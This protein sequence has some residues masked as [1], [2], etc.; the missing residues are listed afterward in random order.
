M[1]A[2]LHQISNCNFTD[3][4]SCLCQLTSIIRFDLTV[5]T[6]TSVFKCSNCVLLCLSIH[7]CHQRDT[8]ATVYNYNCV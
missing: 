1:H 3:L 2:E 8:T 5:H 4:N 7:V 6:Y